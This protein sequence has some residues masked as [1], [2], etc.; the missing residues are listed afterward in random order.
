MKTGPEADHAGILYVATVWTQLVRAFRQAVLPAFATHVPEEHGRLR[1]ARAK[2]C[3]HA[4]PR[5][6]WKPQ[7]TARDMR[8]E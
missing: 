3:P 1:R 2:F 8:C 5:R 6:T 4:G 7:R